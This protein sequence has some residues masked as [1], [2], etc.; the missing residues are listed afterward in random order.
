[1]ARNTSLVT[2]SH[3][4][5]RRDIRLLASRARG[6]RCYAVLALAALATLLVASVAQA[7][8]GAF[9]P[10]EW[11]VQLR[12]AVLLIALGGLAFSLRSL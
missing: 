2:H 12:Q 4:T 9:Q 5:R 3:K 7:A 8:G 6:R 1:M 11:S 10:L